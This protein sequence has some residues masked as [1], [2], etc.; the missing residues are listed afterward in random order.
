MS[1]AWKHV[2]KLGRTAEDF[3]KTINKEIHGKKILLIYNKTKAKEKNDRIIKKQ[4]NYFFP[5]NL[6]EA[7]MKGTVTK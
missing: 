1:S 3:D 6:C 7:F 4:I 2:W 5:S